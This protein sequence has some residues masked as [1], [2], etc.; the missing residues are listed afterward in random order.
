MFTKK[1][2]Q[3]IKIVLYAL[4]QK[5]KKKQKPVSVWRIESSEL[6]HQME[7]YYISSDCHILISL[8]I[9]SFEGRDNH[10]FG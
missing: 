9:E 7:F 10:I 5:K 3:T 4:N 2:H 8:K 6:N 1:M